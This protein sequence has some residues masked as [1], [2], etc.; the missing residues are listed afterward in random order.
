MK[1]EKYFFLIYLIISEIIIVQSDIINDVFHFYPYDEILKKN[2]EEYCLN[3]NL[4]EDCIISKLSEID[5]TKINKISYD[6][7]KTN[8][9]NQINPSIIGDIFENA[10]KGY[11]STYEDD[12]I[13]IIAPIVI[14]GLSSLASYGKKILNDKNEHIILEVEKLLKTEKYQILVN[15]WLKKDIEKL[16]KE[17]L[18]QLDKNKY[19]KDLYIN[20]KNLDLKS[21]FKANINSLN[22]IVFGNKDIEKRKFMNNILCLKS[23]LDMHKESE[24]DSKFTSVKF[25]KYKNN[26]K[27]G[28]EL[29]EANGNEI[30]D[31]KNVVKEFDLYFNDKII[32][33]EKRFIYEFIYITNNDLLEEKDDLTQLFTNHYGKIPL[34]VIKI[35]NEKENNFINYILEEL[36]ENKLKN[37]YKYYYSLNVFKI[38]TNKIILTNKL[39]DIFSSIPKNENKIKNSGD[40][41]N[42]IVNKLKLNINT[43]LLNPILNYEEISK[44]IKNIYSK[45]FNELNKDFKKKNINYTLEED[46]SSLNVLNYFIENHPNDIIPIFFYEKIR[47][48]LEEIFVNKIKGIIINYSFYIEKYPDYIR[49]KDIIY[50]NFIISPYQIVIWLLIIILI[51]L[52]LIIISIYFYRHCQKNKKDTVQEKELD[53]IIVSKK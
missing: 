39:V 3:M 4:K 13:G 21:R 49:I 40:A 6:F 41:T 47:I 35:K 33:D 51:A 10:L 27:Q 7:I 28:I 52:T 44:S 11:L 12:N 24:T 8:Y 19:I 9:Q 20:H 14:S 36:N 17:G 31:F 29:I 26:K 2:L 37:I 43:L 16:I 48:L 1:N 42:F 38:I 34:K 23:E 22:F 25:T 18:S 30:N 15:E 50:R 32:S 5:I 45:F 53:E 46:Q